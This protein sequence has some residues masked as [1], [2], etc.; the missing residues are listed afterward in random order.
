MLEEGQAHLGLGRCLIAL[1]DRE[2]AADP[3]LKA[4]AIFTKLQARALSS[5]VDTHLEGVVA[6]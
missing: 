3:L 6:L 4:R 5:E 2:A 1:G